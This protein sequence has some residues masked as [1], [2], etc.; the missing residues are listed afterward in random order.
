[1]TK[2]IKVIG[3]IAILGSLGMAASTTS[4]VSNSE[5]KDMTKTYDS[6]NINLRLLGICGGPIRLPGQ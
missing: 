2:F 3:I 5:V 1:M 6:C 4:N